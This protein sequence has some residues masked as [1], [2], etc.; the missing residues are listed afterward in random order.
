[1]WQE[2]GGHVVPHSTVGICQAANSSLI[3]V[4]TLGT[5]VCQESNVDI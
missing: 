5:I 3:I 1:M 4:L 2:Q